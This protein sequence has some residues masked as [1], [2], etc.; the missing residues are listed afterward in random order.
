MT[1]RTPAQY[2]WPKA[3]FNDKRLTKHFTH[4]RRSKISHVTLHHM[5][6]VST[7]TEASNTKALNGCYTTWQSR[8]ASANY[9]VAGNQ[10]WQFVSDNDAPWADANDTSNQ[11][12]LAIEHANSKGAPGWDIADSTMAT[13]QRLVANLHKLYGLGRPTR[14]TVRVHSDFY[15]TSCPGPYMMAHLDAYIAAAAKIYDTLGE[16]APKPSAVT[17]HGLHWNIAG[18]DVHNGYGAR[19]ATRGPDVGRR[20]KEI[21]FEVF[22]ACE[23]SQSNLRH[24]AESVIGKSWS[25]GAKAIW[26]TSN[27]KL[28]G[29]GRKLY[30]DNLWNYLKTVKYGAGIFATKDGVKF[31]ILEIH[32]DY[33]K[34]A[35]QAKQ[36][37]SIFAKFRKDSDALGIKHVNQFVVGDFNWDGTSGDDPF[38]A[39]A[40]YNFEEKG[41]HTAKTFQTGK[42]L[43][44]V[45]A[46]EEAEVTVKV[47]DR[48]NLSDHYPVEFTAKLK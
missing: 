33:R 22:L 39:L 48:V 23:A 7:G 46:H 31:S 8:E 5:T 41:S 18:S 27:I 45:L 17:L 47:R 34:G 26:K 19:N 14:K 37:A 28:L 32:T 36:V 16:P 12:T 13:G 35:K 15:A 21:G 2:D 29:P 38:K 40:S 24:G 11:A 10:V 30:S 20:A 43:D 44:G 4:P 25:H 6:I 9:G 1:S 3:L 42:H